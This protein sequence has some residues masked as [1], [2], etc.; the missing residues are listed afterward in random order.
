MG[1]IL[2]IQDLAISYGHIE[3]VRGISLD[4]HEG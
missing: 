3:A 4:L 1:V 2:Q